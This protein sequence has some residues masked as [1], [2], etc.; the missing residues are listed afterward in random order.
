[1]AVVLSVCGLAGKWGWVDRYLHWPGNVVFPIMF[2]KWGFPGPLFTSA[3]VIGAITTAICLTSFLLHCLTYPSLQLQSSHSTLYKY[4]WY[5]SIFLLIGCLIL[6]LV[7]LCINDKDGDYY[8]TYGRK[9]FVV[10]LGVSMLDIGFW[11]YGFR[12][13]KFWS[14]VP[15]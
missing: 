8:W 1:M 5:V 2:L 4:H 13:V 14:A 9:T 12:R 7:M 6:A 11:V 3:I 15:M 10:F